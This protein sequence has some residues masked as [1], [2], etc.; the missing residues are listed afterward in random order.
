MTMCA[1]REMDILDP[2]METLISLLR[3]CHSC[4]QV[5]FTLNSQTQVKLLLPPRLGNGAGRGYVEEKGA[6]SV[7]ACVRNTKQIKRK[8]AQTKLGL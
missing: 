1:E 7:R 8:E 2:R 5:I 4:C 3:Y 6:I